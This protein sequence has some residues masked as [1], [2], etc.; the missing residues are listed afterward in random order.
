M[1]PPLVSTKLM[2]FAQS[3]ELP[4]PSATSA[5]MPRAAATTR[6]ASTMSVSGFGEKSWKAWAAMPAAER[7]ATACAGWPVDWRPGS[8][9]RSVRVKPRPLASAPSSVKRFSPKRTCVRRSKGK[10]I[11]VC[12]ETSLDAARTSACAT[13]LL[14]QRPEFV[15]VHDEQGAVGG[16]YCCIHRAAH[17]DLRD[18]L[19]LLGR[20][21]HQNVSVLIAHVD[22]AV[23]HHGR[24][25]T[26]PTADRA[27]N[28]ACPC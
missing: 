26:P 21:Q 8:E 28:T 22:L 20:L 1:L 19:L 4:P 14:A 10:A 3:S 25:P 24:S 27:S 15:A 11:L 16:H 6:P 17:V 13:S 7:S 2:P 5:S 18:Q 9:T 12:V 23:D